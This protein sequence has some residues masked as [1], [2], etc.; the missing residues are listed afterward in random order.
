MGAA[1]VFI[2]RNPQEVVKYFVQEKISAEN[3]I[4]L[5]K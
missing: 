1:E 5:N 4:T 2:S 3:F